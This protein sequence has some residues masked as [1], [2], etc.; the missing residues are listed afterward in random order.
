M[1]R[2]RVLTLYS[3][4]GCHLCERLRALVDA[5]QPEFGF[6]VEEVDITQNATLFARYQREIPVLLVD[7]VEI[8]R[9]R[10]REA[11]LR[12]LVR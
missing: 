9:G 11:T 10:M 7:G 2:P 6:Q 12:E 3:K 1:T 8:G 4:P 5:L